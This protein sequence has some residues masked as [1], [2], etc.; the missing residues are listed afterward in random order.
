MLKR[1]QRVRESMSKVVIGEEEM[2]KKSLVALLS[3]GHILIEGVPGVGK[4]LL[5]RTLALLIGGDFKR[6]QFTPD[7]LPSDVT[8]FTIYNEKKKEFF[9][10]K[11]PVFSH[12]LLADEINR[13][14]PRTQ[15]S[16]LEAMEERQI[17]IDGETKSLP[18]PFFVIA[19]QNPI[20][21]S[22]TFPLPEAQLDRFLMKLV[23][24]YPKEKEEQRLLQRF[25]CDNPL[26]RLEPLIEPE[27]ILELQKT[28]KRVKV[29]QEIIEY[30]VSIANATRTH[31]SLCHG[32]SPR[33]SLHLMRSSQGL[34]LLEGRDYVLPD[35]VKELVIPVLGHRL[36]LHDQERLEGKKSGS[37]LEEIVEE[38]SL[39]LPGIRERENGPSE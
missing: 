8:G 5:S 9:F 21:S 16:L 19:T 25:Q 37:I 13:T 10:H 22:G 26:H 33:A 31:P 15:S 4:T 30:I 36:I 35:D 11:G 23:M 2:I 29:T 32:A 28:C 12:I 39:P 24:D 20:E 7:L 38:E 27:T 3:S 6:I 34:A 14:I 1:I 17:T 18:Q